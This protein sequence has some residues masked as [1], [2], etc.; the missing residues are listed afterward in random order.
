MS[1]KLSACAPALSLVNEWP[2]RPVPSTEDVLSAKE[3]AQVWAMVSGRI[4][5]NSEALQNYRVF[6]A[7][8]QYSHLSFFFFLPSFFL[9]YTILLIGIFILIFNSL[10]QPR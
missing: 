4:C 7:G 8:T 3:K 6:V 1:S 2:A 9:C 5:R 10:T